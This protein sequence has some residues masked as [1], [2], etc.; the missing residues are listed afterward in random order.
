LTK[1]CG[2]NASYVAFDLLTLEGEDLRLR[3][4]EE[5]RTALSLLVADG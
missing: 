3:P 2:E 5:R 1:R 4:L